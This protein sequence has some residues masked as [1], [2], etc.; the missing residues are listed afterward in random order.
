MKIVV[1]TGAGISQE[2][3]IKTFRDSNGLWENHDIYDVAHPTGWAKDRT[4][5]NRFYNERRK[6]LHE[7]EPNAAHIALTELSKH[8]DVTIVTQN[9]DDLHERSGSTNVL[10]LHG[11]LFKSRDEVTNETFEC[12]GD[13]NDDDLSPNGYTL[14]PHVVW[15]EEPVPMFVDAKN[16]VAQA[17]MLLIIGTS[18]EVYPAAGLHLVAPKTCKLHLFNMEHTNGFTIGIQHIGKAGTTVPKFIKTLI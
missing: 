6:Q 13:L 17:D 8:H 14:R 18:M 5:V 2:S 12:T 10:H 9:I 1:L 7:C 16:I 11:E 3:G 4:M 15:F